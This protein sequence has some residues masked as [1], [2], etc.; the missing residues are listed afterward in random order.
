MLS[1]I[2]DRIAFE[3]FVP[4]FLRARPADDWIAFGE[5]TGWIDRIARYSEG[6]PLIRPLTL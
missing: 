3:P 5:K 4:F 6:K 1:V 2:H